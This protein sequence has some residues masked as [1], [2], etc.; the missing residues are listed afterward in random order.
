MEVDEL[1]TVSVS[2]RFL[3]PEPIEAGMVVLDVSVPT[4]FAPV[5]QSIEEMVVRQPKVKRHDVAGR[6]VILYIE[7]MAPGESLS[8]RFQAQAL[9]PVRA[10]AVTSQV[11]SYYKPEWK[12][13][14]IGGEMVVR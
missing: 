9:Y 5:M 13:E 1:I 6:K 8:F 4:G 11:Y 10:Q 7:D 14:S 3:P 2:V 12:G